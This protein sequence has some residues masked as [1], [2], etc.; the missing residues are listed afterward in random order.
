MD[1]AKEQAAMEQKWASDRGLSAADITNVLT[2]VKG[3][4]TPT[5]P[6]GG[7]YVFN[8][9]GSQPTCSLSPVHKLPTN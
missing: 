5:C 8:N 9:I 6:G 7:T 3:S 1:A 2:Y 4:A